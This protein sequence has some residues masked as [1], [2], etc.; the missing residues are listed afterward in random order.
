M[1][2]WIILML[3]ISSL[4][5]AQEPDPDAIVGKIDDITY[6]YSEYENI[7]ANYYSFY[8]QRQGKPLSDEDKARLNNQCWEELVGR[9]VYD[10]A[11]EADKIQIT[12][13]ELLREAKRNPPAIVR[14]IPDLVKNGVFDQETYEKALDEAT[15]FREAVLDEVRSLYKYD[16]LLDTIRSEV[17]V[18][19]DSV[20]QAWMHEQETV[21]AQIIFFDANKL[22]SVNATEEDA[23]QFYEARKEE[24]RLDNCRRLK[25]VHFTKTPSAEDSLAVRDSIMQM[26]H[27]LLSGADFE[28][29]AREHSDDRG[30]AV[31][32]GDL[33]WFGRGR[34]I[35]A[36]EEVAFSTP[37]GEIAEPVLSR[38]GWHIIEV[39]ERRESESGTE[40]R[41]RHILLN[42]KPGR[43]TLQAM[44]SRSS[45]LFALANEKGLE[46]AAEEMG[47][48]VLETSVF[49]E[50]DGFIQEIGRTTELVD[51]AFSN[52][53]GSLAD[54][55]FA[56]GGDI[57]I[58]AVSAELQ[59]YYVPFEEQKSRIMSAATQA[60]RGYYMHDYVQNF[61]SDLDPEL[62]LPVA[63]RDSIMVLEITGHR[64]GES[65]TS[66]GKN[67][68]LDGALFS[69]PEGTFTPLISE[70]MRWFLAKIVKHEKP[71][72][73]VWERDKDVVIRKAREEAQ[74][75]HLNKWYLEQR[76][77]V[78]ITDNRMDFYDLSAYR[79]MQQ[80]Q[81]GH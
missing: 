34:M 76:N 3:F 50:E 59:V 44:K 77:K 28:K 20:R 15:K 29:M 31:N 62:Y 73:A 11:I 42:I 6:T 56:P 54:I 67:E 65:I 72:P 39:L 74:Q 52:P 78:D 51:F 1:K 70:Q 23:R 19:V 60:K 17:D 41:A 55:Y 79:Q 14:Q 10:Q 32:G 49:R 13:Q 53:V 25:Y 8:E 18:E 45:Q 9:Y 43:E 40:V 81:L 66:I 37:V 30:S 38:F 7:L 46:E 47:L 48:E 64:K 16:K 21:D 57:F 22:T 68:E 4:L 80:I 12:R 35:P 33:G 36:F 61:V 71:D 58:C 24:F 5:W 27:E 2:R 63:E 75:E 26:Y 69:T